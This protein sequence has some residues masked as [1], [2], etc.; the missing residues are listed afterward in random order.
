MLNK[1]DISYLLLIYLIVLIAIQFSSLG[2]SEGNYVILRGIIIGLIILIFLFSLNKSL[3]STLLKSKTLIIHSLILFLSIIVLLV[4]I[5]FSKMDIRISPIRDLFLSLIIMVIGINLILTKRQFNRLL[6]LFIISF[7]LSALSIVFKYSNG[8]NILEYYL[9]IPK[10]QFAPAFGTAFIISLYIA[11]Q[12][13]TKF[14]ILY[15]FLSVLLLAS[16]LVIRGRA[17][18]VS[19]FITTFIIVFFYIKNK[20]YKIFTIFIIIALLPYIDTFIYEALFLN[21]DLTDINS[22]STGRLERNLEG[23]SFLIEYPLFGELEHK[24]SGLTIHNYILYILVSYGIILGAIILIPF[25]KYISVTLMG[26]KRNSYQYYEVG[27]LVMVILL[28]ISMFEYTYPYSPGS[29]TFFPFF[30]LGQ[31]IQMNN[32]ISPKKSL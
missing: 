24:F 27:P 2:I 26:I 10:N 13:D 3:I 28:I 4:V 1:N 30:L 9:P 6:L 22:I 11:F 31:Y 17:T 7:T 16:L 20:K 18:L 25:L 14:K 23:I 32:K 8:F 29:S 21:Y 19:V 12:K 15:F 5:P